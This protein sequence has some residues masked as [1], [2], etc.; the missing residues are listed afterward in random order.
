MSPGKPHP[1]VE[2]PGVQCKHEFPFCQSHGKCWVLFIET[3]SL[4]A[5]ALVAIN[6]PVLLNIDF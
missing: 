6:C 1:Q 5:V 3:S 2:R 4:F